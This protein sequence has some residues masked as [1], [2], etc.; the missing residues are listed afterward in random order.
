MATFLF[1]FICLHSDTLVFENIYSQWFSVFENP[2]EFRAL[3]PSLGPGYLIQQPK[4]LF[5]NSNIND[6][7]NCAPGNKH[8]QLSFNVFPPKGTFETMIFLFPFGGI[9]DRS[10]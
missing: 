7:L 1:L 8:H 5:S 6:V 10:P 4:V 2:L 3:Y 9:C